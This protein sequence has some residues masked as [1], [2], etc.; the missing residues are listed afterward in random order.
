MVVLHPLIEMYQAGP[1]P[2]I[3]QLSWE[4]PEILQEELESVT[5]DRGV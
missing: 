2:D 1:N 5:M 4:H 3:S